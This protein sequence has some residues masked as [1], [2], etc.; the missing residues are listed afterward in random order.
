MSNQEENYIF[1]YSDKCSNK[2]IGF[3]SS[4]NYRRNRTLL[5]TPNNSKMT[6]QNSN[7][8]NKEYKLDNEKDNYLDFTDS[9]SDKSFSSTEDNYNKDKKE[10]SDFHRN[11]R[12]SKTETLALF[13]KNYDILYNKIKEAKKMSLIK[14][15]NQPIRRKY[16]SISMGMDELIKKLENKIEY[17]NNTENINDFYEYTEICFEH[18]SKLGKKPKIKEFQYVNLNFSDEEK[19]KKIALLDLD[20]TLIHCI[21]EIK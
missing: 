12:I 1:Y 2:N 11:E 5:F 8:K 16:R 9:E 19:N 3:S 17:F 14:K 10:Y 15:D 6:Y 7:I 21:G 4:S 20:E 13:N 18:I